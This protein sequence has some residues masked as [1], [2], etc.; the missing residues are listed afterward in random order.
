MPCALSVAFFLI[1][2]FADLPDWMV[3]SGLIVG[4]AAL[5]AVVLFVVLV[6]LG[7]WSLRLIDRILRALHWPDQET[8]ARFWTRL[9]GR[10]R[11][12]FLARLPWADR[13]ALGEMARLPDRWVQRGHDTA[14]GT[15]PPVFGRSLIWAVI[16]AYYWIV[17]L[18]FE[19]YGPTVR[20]R[21]G[22]RL[23]HGSGYDHPVLAWLYR[24]F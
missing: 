7:R 10:T 24:R 21:S 22:R 2:P 6:E 8:M 13:A 1:L 23:D 19:A 9:A 5:V 15:A 20:R 18:A 4:V 12:G 17:L 14:I 16:S 11:L 3:R